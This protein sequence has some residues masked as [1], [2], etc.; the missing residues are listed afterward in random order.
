MKCPICDSE[1]TQ[2]FTSYFCEKCDE[3][4]VN[5]KPSESEEERMKNWAKS[6]PGSPGSKLT[7]HKCI[8]GGFVECFYNTRSELL[9]I[10]VPNRMS[11][12]G[13]NATWYFKKEDVEDAVKHK[14]LLFE[15]GDEFWLPV[16]DKS[17]QTKLGPLIITAEFQGASSLIK[18][19]SRIVGARFNLYNTGYVLCLDK[20]DVVALHEFWKSVV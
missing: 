13:F 6:N 2:L 3:K 18:P 19:G 11:P 7:P 9:S 20:C 17:G 15:Q 16:V 14:W 4:D 12:G 1:M 5:N 10:I 8:V